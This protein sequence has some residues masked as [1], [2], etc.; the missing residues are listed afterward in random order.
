[1][2]PRR[3]GIRFGIYPSANSALRIAGWLITDTGWIACN[4]HLH[5]DVDPQTLYRERLDASLLYNLLSVMPSLFHPVSERHL[6]KREG[7]Y[8]LEGCR[9]ATFDVCGHSP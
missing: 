7:T 6:H 1:L 9:C 4:V 3:T 5:G 8:N 2:N